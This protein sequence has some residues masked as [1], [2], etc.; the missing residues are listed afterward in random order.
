[1]RVLGLG[2][3]TRGRTP[4]PCLTGSIGHKL[5]P[6]R[7]GQSLPPKI[8]I[9]NR[10]HNDVIELLK[11]SCEVVGNDTGEPWPCDVLR[12]HARDAVG[13]M[14]F[15]TDCIDRRFLA[16]CPKLR[17]VASVL[18]GADNF[19]VEACTSRG[20]WLTVVPQGLTAA[21]A[22]LTIGLMLALSRHIV[23]G[24]A[25]VRRE[26]S[27]WRPIL[28]GRGLHGSTVGIV[29]MGA[30]GRAVAARLNPFGCSI[31]YSDLQRLS[32]NEERSLGLRFM[33]F[34]E[35]VATC[36]FVVLAVPLTSTTHHVINRETLS[37]MKRTCIL[38]NPARG[39][40]VDE[41]AVADALGAG[42]LG[43]YA[44]DVFEMEDWAREDRPAGIP[45][46]LVRD[47][48]HTVL[49]PHLGSAERQVRYA[50]EMEM[51]NSIID[52][53]EGRTP[54][55]AINWPTLSEVGVAC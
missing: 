17:I 54:R 13:V 39:S 47:R 37:R 7:T 43:G 11:P 55:G 23:T 30:I 51:A 33:P 24:D 29:G 4:N 49:T 34:G 45:D 26:Y 22:E 9:S 2:A 42:H 10:V 50:A 5:A 27:G 44:A 8:V 20:V 3:S 14:A 19:D 41:E 48:D 53:V 35:L 28:Y 52:C 38:V 32:F 1:M 25:L 16:S 15:M 46:R 36:D 18:K 21:T 12:E 6:Q 31:C 40:V